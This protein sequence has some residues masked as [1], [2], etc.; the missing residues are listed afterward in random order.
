MIARIGIA[1]LTTQ[2]TKLTDLGLFAKY[3]TVVFFK[4]LVTTK[5]MLLFAGF[6]WFVLLFLLGSVTGQWHWFQRSGALIIS[7]ANI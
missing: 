3:H 2:S 1:S 7:E 4:W 6:A 5:K